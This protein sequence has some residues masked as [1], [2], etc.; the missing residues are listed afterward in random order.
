M[1]ITFLLALQKFR[2]S[3]PPFWE[4][5]FNA[6]S[7]WDLSVYAVLFIP[8][9]LYWC[10]D[11][12][13]G[14]VIIFSYVG[15]RFINAVLK[16]TVCCYRPWIR[17]PRVIPSPA[18]LGGAGGYSFPSGH[19]SSGMGLFGSAGWVFRRSFF[20]L[21]TAVLWL[22]VALVMFSRNFLGVHTPQDV[23]V[24]AAVGVLAVWLSGIF[25]SWTEGEGSASGWHRDILV[26]VAALAC[27]AV[28]LAYFVAK[29]YPVDYVDGRVLVDP[30][31]M[32]LSSLKQVGEL[33]GLF[34]GWFI[35]RRLIRFST[36]CSVPEKLARFGLLAPGLLWVN[37]R[38]APLAACFFGRRGTVIVSRFAFVF[39]IVCVAPLV[40]R[41]LHLL[42]V[43]LSVVLPA[44]H[45]KCRNSA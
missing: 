23:L 16:L 13:K 27:C 19:S 28:T 40:C 37:S 26:L 45:K 15:A 22:F 2:A 7:V 10:L 4:R 30:L 21:V 5:F 38:S 33:A 24:G 43:R 29:P 9:L 31:A 8:C 39:Y 14:Q 36:D 17:D 6:V 34:I 3:L 42:F 25:L 1:D 44:L 11:K 12:R 18:A 41:L 32:Q 35:E 20:G